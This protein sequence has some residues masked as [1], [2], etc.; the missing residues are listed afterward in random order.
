MGSNKD[1]QAMAAIALL[2]D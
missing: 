2:A 1:H